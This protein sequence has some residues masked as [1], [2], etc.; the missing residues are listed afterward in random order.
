MTLAAVALVAG[1]GG[2]PPSNVF[3]PPPA[4]AAGLALRWVGANAGMGEIAPTGFDYVTTDQGDL[5]DIA[6][7]AGYNVFRIVDWMPPKPYTAADWTQVRA[8]ALATGI[9]L[10]P[11]LAAWIGNTADPSAEAPWVTACETKADMILGDAGL[12]GSPALAFV[13]IVNE[14]DLTGWGL[15]ALAQ[16]SAY[17][18]SKYP[19]VSLTVG[20]WGP[21]LENG[22]VLPAVTDMVSPHLYSWQNI[23]FNDMPPSQETQGVVTELGIVS[24]YA[25]SQ[26][27]VVE[28][29]GTPSGLLAFSDSNTRTAGSPDSQA[30]HTDAMLAGIAQARGR[31]MSVDGAIVWNLYPGYGQSGWFEQPNADAVIVPQGAGLPF[32]VMP[33]VL[34]LCKAT[35]SECAGAQQLLKN[36][37][38]QK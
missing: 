5:F 15:D 30:A 7:K 19:G 16:I 36:P 2:T 9:A 22:S 10:I 26:H 12:A 8:R 33:A 23:S 3:A 34:E 32:K 17:V 35:G 37:P 1:C 6:Q 28:E 4:A 25:R 14:P 18:H 20:G 27:M 11:V 24:N 38:I 13:D 31:G 21:S 29:F